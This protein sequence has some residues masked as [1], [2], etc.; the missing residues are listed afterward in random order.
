MPKPNPQFSVGFLFGAIDDRV[1]HGRFLF[2]TSRPYILK[3]RITLRTAVAL[4]A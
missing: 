1:V 2:L 4:V 3:E